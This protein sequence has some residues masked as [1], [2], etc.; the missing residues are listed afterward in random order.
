MLEVRRNLLEDETG[1]EPQLTAREAVE[2]RADA[3]ARDGARQRRARADVRAV[4]EG[5]VL[6]GIAAIDMEVVGVSEHALVAIRR[7]RA[8]DDAFAGAHRTAADLGVAYATASQEQHR[9][10]EA[11]AL[12]DRGRQERAIGAQRRLELGPGRSSKMR[13]PSN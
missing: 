9:R 5:E 12:F 11:E 6:V 1:L 4:A 3:D 8:D 10:C 2:D 7:S 13:L